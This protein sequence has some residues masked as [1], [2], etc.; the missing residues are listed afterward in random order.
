MHRISVNFLHARFAPVIYNCINMY[1]CHCGVK[2]THTNEFCGECGGKISSK[3]PAVANVVKPIT[4]APPA[5]HESKE[6]T[7]SF[8]AFFENRKKFVKSNKRKIVKKDVA[9]EVKINVSMLRFINNALRQ[10][11]GSRTPVMISVSANY[12]EVKRAAYTKL[13]RYVPELQSFK[14][15]DLELC[16]RTGDIAL[17]LPGTNTEFS[18]EKYKEDLGVKYSQ[19][20]LY[21]K[22]YYADRERSSCSESEDSAEALVEKKDRRFVS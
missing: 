2:I 8:N 11:N 18:V 16:Y 20:V 15:S 22:P 6:E 19:M 13:K 3:Q 7:L 9:E 21:L 10:V 5:P 12:D 4:E 14:Y 1:C 17:T